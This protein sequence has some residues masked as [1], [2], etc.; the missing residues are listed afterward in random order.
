MKEFLRVFNKRTLLLL[1]ILCFLNTGIL[2]LCADPDKSITLTGEELDLYVQDYPKFLERTISNGKTMSLLNVYQSG[3]A[4]DRIEK[5]S[6]QYRALEGLQVVKA[7]NRGLVL[8]IQYRLTDIFLLAFLF[9]IVMSFFAERKKGLVYIVRSTENGRAVL[10]LQRLAILIC[11]AVV[12]G[13]LLYASAFAGIHFTFGM[14]GLERNI[15]SLPEFMKCP[16][17]ITIGEYLLSSCLLKLAGSLLAAVLLYVILGIFSAFAGYALAGILLL[18]EV[19][20]ALFIEPISAVNH[21]LYL[22]LLTIIQADHYFT[23]C[24]YLNIF[25][26][27]VSALMICQILLISLLIILAVTGFIV[28]GRLYVNTKRGLERFLERIHSFFERHALQRTLTGWEVYKLYIKQGALLLFS[29]L[30]V[31]QI[32][33]TF[34]YQYYYPVNAMERLYYI[35]FEGEITEELSEKVE[36]KMRMLQESEASLRQTLDKLWNSVPFNDYI[37]NQT[38]DYL[39]NNL[40]MQKGLQPVLENIRNGMEYTRRTGKPIHLIQPY[41]Y[42]LLINR[43]HHVKQ[44][45]SFLELIII[46]GSLAGIYAYDSQNHMGQII[47]T[48]YRGRR[49]NRIRKPLIGIS[50]CAF[51]A[52]ALHGVQM[53][54]IG[55]SMGFNNLDAPIQSLTFMR[56]FPLYLSIRGYLLVLFLLRILFASVLGA[57]IM[58]LSRLCRDTFTALGL[59]TFFCMLLFSLSGLLPGLDFINPIYLLS[60]NFFS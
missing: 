40:A 36:H 18:A 17:S 19:I 4:S 43:D 5:V 39:N 47:H 22:N 12:S 51:T 9:L 60:A 55:R 50:L 33:L 54:H 35:E 41:T 24:I 31:L 56:N 30:L 7:D 8:F 16:Y 46:L 49:M 53:V 52:I 32:H 13:C 34:R 29:V 20:F 37:Y 44:R 6:E 42:D 27:A 58:S 14:N 26:K 38:S 45:A 23:D 25:G 1:A 11:A 57:I 48:S 3:F 2:M 15:Q 21:L 28:H 59:G 10:F